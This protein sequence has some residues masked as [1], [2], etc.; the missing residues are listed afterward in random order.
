MKIY[1]FFLAFN[2]NELLKGPDNM[3]D[4]AKDYWKRYNGIC[5]YW[6]FQR[7][8]Y[9]QGFSSLQRRIGGEPCEDTIVPVMQDSV[10]GERLSCWGGSD[11]WYVFYY[12]L[13]Q[14]FM[15]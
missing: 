3:Q 9:S 1:I 4:V 2:L 15:C 10:W 13:Q 7:A 5:M 14:V 11:Y 8:T 6:K 12:V